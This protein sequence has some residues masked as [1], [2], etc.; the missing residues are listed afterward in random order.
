[1]R[2]MSSLIHIA[3]EERKYSRKA[4]Q[5]AP[6]G[7]TT[8]LIVGATPESDRQIISLSEALYH[9]L[10]LRRV[11][12]SAFVPVSEDSRLPVL[13]ASPTLRE[14]RL[15]QADWL[16]RFYGFAAQELLDDSHPN[17]DIR[18]D[19]KSDWA[20]RHLE[21]FPIEANQADLEMLLRVPGIGVRSAQRIVQARRATSLGQQELKRLGVVLKRAK[22]FLTAGGR[23][24][25]GMKLEARAILDSLLVP[26]ETKNL[27]MQLQL[28]PLEVFQSAV[29]GEL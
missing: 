2:Q 7:Q 9:R 18:L 16:L 20:L 25:G 21:Q 22:H 10:A 3:T 12:Y 29:S 15:Y 23:Y 13:A 6:A 27:P 5:F 11:Y 4:P 28:F 26:K 14:H 17:L 19:P 1:M 24:L 8:Q